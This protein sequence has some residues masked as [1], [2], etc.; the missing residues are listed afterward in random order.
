MLLSGKIL[1]HPK[2]AKIA[3]IFLFIF[4][5][6]TIFFA[7]IFP[8]EYHRII[9]GSL[10]TLTYLASVLAIRKYRVRLFSAA[11]TVVIVESIARIFELR[12]ISGISYGLKVIFFL[13]IVFFLV[14]QLARSKKVSQQ[15][16]LEAI[17]VYLLLGVVFS[18]LITFSMIVNVNSFSFPFRD[19]I[20]RGAIYHF[21]DYLY[22]GFVTFTTL[23]YGDII[24]LTPYA[25]TLSTLA[26]VSGQLYVAIIIAMLVGKFSNENKYE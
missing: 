23:G 19:S 12:I 11:V 21:G 16:I 26:S 20:T 22:Y 8:M 4:L 1:N 3:N 17:N 7:P 25:K 13:M 14:V 5:L 18:L 24:P 6:L 10:L 15:V 2:T 9:F